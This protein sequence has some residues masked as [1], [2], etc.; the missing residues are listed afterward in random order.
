MLADS[1]KN[2]F[3]VPDLRKRVLFTLGL[4]AV[5]R[6]GSHIPTPGINP[7]AL[8]LLADQARN[9]MFGLYDMFSGQNLS[10]MTIFALGIMPY[11]SASIILQLLTVVWPY[12][13]RLSKEGELG[14]RKITQYTRYG[15]IL[16][17][18]VQSLGIAYFLERSTEVAG[19]LPLVFS[20]GWGFRLMTVL[21]LTT[22]SAFVMWLGEQITERGI[23][24]GMSLIIFAGIV[25]GLPQ[26]V[27]ITLDQLRTG[28]MGPIRLLLLLVL[29]VIVIGAI[30]FV[31]RGHRRV[32]VQYAKRVV[33][34]RMYGGSSTHIPLKVNTG[35]VIPVI[36]ASS[37]LTFPITF[38]GVFAPDSWAAATIRQIS[39]GMPLYNLLYVLGIIFFAYFYTAIIF[40]PDDVSENMRKYGG[41]IPG[42]R[43]GKR[44]AEYIDTILARITLV[45]AVYLAIVAIIPEFLLTGFRVEPIP[46][47][48]PQI[49]AVLPRFITEGLGV[50]FFFG[51]TSLL[52]VVGVAMDTVNQVESQ[53]IMRHY[54]GFMKKTRIRGRRG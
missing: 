41:F 19:G 40:N 24:N 2:I 28:Q 51:G 22:G 39:P 14:R 27:I 30:V 37:I 47:I 38:S 1:L 15:T 49:D 20:P 34:R 16:L 52:I 25:V 29:M 17:S 13:E 26:A 31:E 23:G 35:G 4:L 43:P 7:E 21:T 53:L 10:Q 45:G 46:V 3:A 54:D 5:Y 33:G 36:F 18:V 11:I 8:A 44:T 12:L 42:I 9:T 48:G 50:T 32:T 6:V